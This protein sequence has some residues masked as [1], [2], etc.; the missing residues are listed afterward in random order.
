[1]SL[2]EK[3]SKFSNE[4]IE[5]I[6]NDLIIK[7]PTNKYNKSAP[8]KEIGSYFLDSN[9]YLYVPLA[10]GAIDLNLPRRSREKFPVMTQKFTGSLRDEQINVQ[11][12][13]LK[14]LSKTGSIILS[15]HTGFGKTILS[16]NLACEIRLKTLIIVNK[17][18]LINQWE[19]S[20]L[21]FCPTAKIQKL[22]TKS[23][24]D[25]DCNF[26]IMNAT[27]V[28][29]KKKS[30]FRNIGLCIVDECFP[31]DTP[32]LT[33]K[34]YCF[35]GEIKKDQIVVTFNE[36]TK[37]FENNKV[38]AFSKKETDKKIVK[39]HFSSGTRTIKCTENHRFLSSTGYK[40]ASNLQ[41]GDLIVSF[42]EFKNNSDISRALN[43]DQKQI[44]LGSYLG[45]GHIRILKSGRYRMTITHCKN[46]EQYCSW[47]ASIFGI[48]ELY[49]I[50]ENGYSKKPAVSFTTK[51][52]DMEKNFLEK[53]TDCPDWIMN[54]ID[55][56]GLA[57]WYMDDGNLNKYGNE[58]KIYTNSFSCECVSKLINM[59]YSKFNIQ[60]ILSY[61]KK[62]PIIR[63]NN[64]N[65]KLFLKLVA[66]Y[67]HDNLKYK[68]HVDTYK[69]W[70]EDQEKTINDIFSRKEFIPKHLLIENN[71][72]KAYGL[73]RT[74]IRNYIWKFCKKCNILFFHAL[75][76]KTLKCMRHKN[77]NNKLSEKYNVNWDIKLENNYVWNKNFHD[78]GY[79]KVQSVNTC[80]NK[81]K[82]VYDIETENN[83]NFIVCSKTGLNGPVVHNCHL[84]MAESLSKSLQCI[85]PRYL[86]GLSATP[87]RMDGLDGLLELYFGKN[88]IIRLLRRKHIVYKVKTGITIKMALTE[89]GKINWGS[90]LDEQCN[91]IER[92]EIIISICKK[93]NDRNILIL[94][95]RVE[96]G[97]YLYNRLVEDK[98]NVASLLGSQQEFDRECR[99]LVATT[100]KA[101]TGFDFS[102]LDCLIISSDLE[103][104]FVQALGR[105]L[106]RPDVE[107][108][109]FDLIDENKILEK[110][111]NSR[112]EVYDEIGG[113]IRDYSIFMK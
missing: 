89:D 1:M 36:K 104:Y 13:A 62:K 47:K 84:I 59:L 53:K 92:N 82:F 108:I 14:I 65:V 29:K 103:S 60:A 90:I 86:I 61:D 64:Y 76:G 73:N 27:N 106:R 107:P 111:F 56:R 15:L 93:F 66:P 87:Y 11:K 33:P 51:F 105:V 20:I 34:G 54:E 18:V 70:L 43:D 72:Y 40:E 4:Q 96:Q 24:F 78:Y 39:I 97:K 79:L 85:F 74:T 22:N 49:K 31:Y 26:F 48:N 81:D 46:Q 113:T 91:N 6:N 88:R 7:I 57:I 25:N 45:D 44:I 112:K 55:E 23:D 10:Y 67:I 80:F 50:K 37:K 41:N 30:F 58:I 101:S 42:F 68:L 69:E 75:D 52:F 100:S 19:E 98:E 5:K 77:K 2:I 8:I 102:K 12:E 38:L 110:H 28:S 21:K 99:I 35:I 71:T 109:V 94:T 83:H 3:A 63:L 16:I 32:V 17:I 9:D 95:K